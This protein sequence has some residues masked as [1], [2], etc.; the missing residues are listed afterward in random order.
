M[1][2]PFAIITNLMPTIEL[3]LIRNN[4]G[5]TPMDHEACH[6][7][8]CFVL[9]YCFYRDTTTIWKLFI[10]L[11][12][13]SETQC[14]TQNY[15]KVLSGWADTV[16]IWPHGLCPCSLFSAT[17]YQILSAC[18]MKDEFAFWYGVFY[19]TVA[20]YSQVQIFPSWMWLLSDCDIL[21]FYAVGFTIQKQEMW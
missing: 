18:T 20:S 1:S 12:G 15:L 6:R 11:Y 17:I 5:H 8:S 21:L 10:H 16:N 14:V 7:V 4:K 2:F 3:L 19:V 9:F 13:L